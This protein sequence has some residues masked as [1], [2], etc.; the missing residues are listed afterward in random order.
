MKF[1][2]MMSGVRVTE[3]DIRLDP[4]FDLTGPIVSLPEINEKIT[5]E[6]SLRF[7]FA[8]YHFTRCEVEEGVW[9]WCTI[10][11]R[12][13]L[14]KIHIL[15]RRPKY[16]EELCEHVGKDWLYHYIRFNH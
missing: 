12:D 2:A 5:R 3:Y 13:D 16:E 8:T 1:E 9:Q 7:I 15:E 6:E 14:Y 10:L 11:S 4:M